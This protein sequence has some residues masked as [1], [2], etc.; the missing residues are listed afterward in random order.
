MIFEFFASAAS[1]VTFAFAITAMTREA[2]RSAM[3]VGVVL[4]FFKAVFFFFLI[5]FFFCLRAIVGD[6]W[7]NVDF[8]FLNPK[9]PLVPPEK[10]WKTPQYHPSLHLLR[11]RG[12]LRVIG[13]WVFLVF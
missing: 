2:G 8:F 9:G 1:Q 3:N 5:V 11:C 7:W 10:G 4:F 13:V 12:T 6:S